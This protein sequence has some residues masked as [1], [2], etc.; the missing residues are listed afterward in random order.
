MR[1]V[2]IS[3]GYGAGWVSWNLNQPRALRAFLLEDPWLV[4]KVEAQDLSSTVLE[5]FKKRVEE[6]FPSLPKPVCYAG[7][8]KLVVEKVPDNCLVRIQEKDGYE[9]LTCADVDWH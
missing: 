5:E 7:W 1:K 9:R 6:R 2:V 8:D 4:S 3:P